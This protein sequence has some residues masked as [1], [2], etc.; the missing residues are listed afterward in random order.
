M[1]DVL[2]SVGARVHI[3]VDPPG[4]VTVDARALDS[5]SPDPAA[6]EK[7]RVVFRSGSHPRAT[8]SRRDAPPRRMRHRRPPG[9]S[10]PPRFRSARRRGPGHTVEGTVIAVATGPGGIALGVAEID[11]EIQYDRRH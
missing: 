4:T 5:H 2:R 11:H 1:I 9:G 7:L 8:R 3:G 10:A 6:V